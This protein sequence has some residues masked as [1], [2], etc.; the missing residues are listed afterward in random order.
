M[1]KKYRSIVL[2]Q[3][4]DEDTP[5]SEW[6]NNAWQGDDDTLVNYLLEYDYDGNDDINDE[7]L[8]GKAD[9]WF[10][11]GNYLVTYNRNLNYVGLEEIIEPETNLFIPKTSIL[12]EEGTHELARAF[13]D[14][15]EEQCGLESMSLDEWV[16][17]HE[18]DLHE[19]DV[20]IARAILRLFPQL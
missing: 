19:Q 13:M 4:P 18:H 3:N 7:S 9:D 8:K 15:Y 2:I 16:L 12:S 6:L 17:E 1:G 20:L 14:V 10:I 11:H 5:V